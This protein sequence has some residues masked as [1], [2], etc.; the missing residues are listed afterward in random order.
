[1]ESK[2]LKEW[3]EEERKEAAKEATL[4]V[5]LGQLEEKFEL[6]P[7][8]IKKQLSEIQD[9][10]TL[11]YLSRK[12]IKAATLEEFEEFLKKAGQEMA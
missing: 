7:R 1:M 10:E 9:Q 4:S 3:T 6:V 2:L 8:R 5:L 12:I 11:R